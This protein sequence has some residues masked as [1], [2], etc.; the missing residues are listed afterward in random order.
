MSYQI[1]PR[2]G[3]D[4]DLIE[5]WRQVPT[6]TLGHLTH[7]GYL[8]GLR[9]LGDGRALTGPALTVEVDARDSRV[10]REALIMAQPGDVL[11]VLDHDRHLGRACF[12]ELRA[13]AAEVKGLAGVVVIGHLTDVAALRSMR[14]PLYHLGVSALTI[15][16]QTR[17]GRLNAP[18]TVGDLHIAPGDLMHGDDDGLFALAPERAKTL[19][20]AALEQEALDRT[21]RAELLAKRRDSASAS[22]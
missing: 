3:L 7:E 6:S 20:P 13:L 17:F 2:V 12:G 22:T 11:V 4:P 16:A 19:L 10:L 21:R 15:H 5:A 18:L 9:P 14:L 1:A 8:H